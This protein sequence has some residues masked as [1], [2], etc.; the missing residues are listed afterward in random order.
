MCES[1]P[2][3]LTNASGTL[4]LKERLGKEIEIILSQTVSNL[5][6]HKWFQKHNRYPP[7][8]WQLQDQSEI[9]YKQTRERHHGHG[10]P[11]SDQ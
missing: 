3:L 10:V 4:T 1:S 7:E 6:T 5:L 8:L 11:Q 2:Y 9:C